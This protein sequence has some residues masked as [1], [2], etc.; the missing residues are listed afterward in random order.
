MCDFSDEMNIMIEGFTESFNYTGKSVVSFQYS[1]QE[2]EE[3]AA[4]L[5]TG[6]KQMFDAA[7]FLF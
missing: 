6:I 3:A 4:A 7:W 5:S 1:N 2:M